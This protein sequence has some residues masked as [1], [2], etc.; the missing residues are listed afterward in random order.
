MAT[1]DLELAF[2]NLRGTPYE[3][4]S[5]SSSAYNCIAWA[6]GETNRWWWPAL[7]YYW[8]AGVTREAT[9]STFVAAFKSLG[10]AVCDDER[11]EA[12][13]EKV[14]V[15]VDAAGVPAHAARQVESGEWTS[16]LGRDVDIRHPNLKSLESP[17]Y[18]LVA[19]IL[20]RSRA[21]R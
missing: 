3:I 9:L 16:K 5:P 7:S 19:Q 8:P 18:G 12:G 21:A 17:L 4:T 14:A 15:Y 11:L 13:F 20:K 2:P 1:H 6:A 10:Y